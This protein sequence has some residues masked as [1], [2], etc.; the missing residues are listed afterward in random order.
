MSNILWFKEIKKKDIPTCGGKGASLGEMFNAGIPVPPGFVVT[1]DAYQHFLETTGIA[2]EIY[3]LLSDLNVENN[4]TLQATAKRI[5]NIIISSEMPPGVKNDIRESYDNLNVDEEV[6]RKAGKQA[7]D[8]IKAGR[9]LP[10]V[11]VRSSATAEDLPT[12]SFAGQQATF[13][14]IRGSNKL[15][16]AVQK[17]WASLFTA[18]AIYYR[19]QNNFPHEKVFIAV[20]IQRMVNSSKSGVIFSINPMTNNEGEIIIEAGWGLGESVV[21]GSITPDQYIVDKNTLTLKTKKVNE[22]DWMY[23]L[24]LREGQTVKKTIPMEKR[25]AQILNDSE[26]RKLTELT[27]KIENHYGAAQDIE[28]AIE[29]PHIYIVQSRPVTT[30]KKP[31]GKKLEEG[32]ISAAGAKV[33]VK[34][35]GASPGVGTGKVKLVHGLEDLGKILQGDVLVARMTNPDYVASMQRASAI[36][37]DEG[38]ATCFSGDTKLLTNKGFFTLKEIHNLINDGENIKTLS[39]NTKNN[40]IIWKKILATSKRKGKLCKIQVSPNSRSKQNFLKVTLDHKFLT[41]RDRKFAKKSIKSILSNNEAVLIADK[42]PKINKINFVGFPPYL[43]GAIFSDGS[44]GINNRGGYNISFHQTNIP[45]KEEFINKV[46]NDFENYYE[47]PFKLQLNKN[48]PDQ[49]QYRCFKKSVYKDLIK[50]KETIIENV[51]SMEENSL[52]D[53]LSGF[54]DGDGTCGDHQLMITVGESKKRFLEA[55]ICACLRLGIMPQVCKQKTWHTIHLTENINGLI[56]NCRRIHKNYPNKRFGYKKFLAKSVMIDI[57]DK[58]NHRGRV[59]HSYIKGNLMISDKYLRNTIIPRIP[60]KREEFLNLL[61]SD[62]RMWR[63][64]LEE[65]LGNQDVY[66]LTIDAENELDHN[67]LVFTSNYSPVIVGNCHAAIVSREMGIPCIVGTETATRILKENEVVTVDANTGKVY[68]GAITIETK[69]EEYEGEKAAIETV[70]EIKV[71]MDLPDYAKKAAETGADGVGLL[72]CEFMILKHQEHPYHMIKTG[73]R[74]ELVKDL[75]DDI[76]KIASAFKGKPV[77][78]RTLDAPTDEFR[79]LKGGEDEPEEDNPMMGWRSIR[80]SLDQP[81]LLLAEFEAIKR[82]HDSGLTNVGVMLPLVTHVDQISKSKEYLRQVGLEP[83]ENIEFGIMIETPASVQIIEEICEEGVDFISFGTNDLT[84][85]TLA[86]DRNS[87][88]VQ[89]WYN[90]KHPAVLRQIKYVIDVCKKHN[91]ETSICGQAGSDPEMA[92]LL[93]KMGIDSISANPD[94]VK[95]IR[96]FVSKAEKKL[97]LSAARKDVQV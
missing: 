29:G 9:D 74:E 71:I 32:T 27:I 73:R 75:T 69:K 76:T 16:E 89:K 38:G 7:L 45:Q 59:K 3:S 81:E 6:F 97:L 2:N 79:H 13:L 41:L 91:V 24:D 68:E 23:T 28:Y 90:E 20:V 88:K 84:Q 43:V 87:A 35:Q 12:A 22:Q 1:A 63:C 60:E 21:S 44:L 30:L 95:K 66:N 42:I 62:F 39:L 11:A 37:T 86:C 49:Y 96:Y 83:M 47:E 58:V 85:F 94:A 52:I 77:W 34:G 55:I 36:V 50:I 46:V 25:N 61:N 31:A 78:Y 57:I 51:L 64:K 82:V 48:R 10:F 93:V 65:S 17:C 4:E 14:N 18:R 5:Q 70:T 72:R 67:Y 56:N 53:F 33:L 80:R 26:I 15:I 40:K 92:E 54:I 8:I 19:V